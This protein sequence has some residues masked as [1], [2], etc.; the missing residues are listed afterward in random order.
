MQNNVRINANCNIFLTF[1]IPSSQ[2]AASKDTSTGVAEGPQTV[3]ATGE[4]AHTDKSEKLRE[5]FDISE[6]CWSL[7]DE[8]LEAGS[9]HESEGDENDSPLSD[10]ARRQLCTDCGVFYSQQRPHV[11]LHKLKPHSCNFCGRRFVDLMSLNSHNRMH[12]M[13]YEHRHVLIKTQLDRTRLKQTHV[14]KERLYQCPDCF[15]TFASRIECSVHVFSHKG[16]PKFK[17]NTCGMQ[18]SFKNSLKVH[19]I[20]HTGERPYACLVCQRRFSLAG[21]LKT[22]MRLHT[23][24]RPYKCEHCEQCF[25]QNISLKLHIQRYHTGGSG[26]GQRKNNIETDALGKKSRKAKDSVQKGKRGNPRTVRSKG[27]S[28]PKKNAA[29]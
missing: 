24:E 6:N 18:F 13:N 20:V 29:E 23:G 16:V 12:N 15:E 21:N 5:K 26:R 25:N 27:S 7:D 19:S 9:L 14:T 11:C 4:G 1:L 22:H 8:I 10:P 28:R 2:A 3:A 17:C